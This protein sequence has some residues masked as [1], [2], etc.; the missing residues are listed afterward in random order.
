VVAADDTSLKIALMG[1]SEQ[2]SA[3]LEYFKTQQWSYNRLVV[4][5]ANFRTPERDA[6]D[7]QQVLQHQPDCHSTSPLILRSLRWKDIFQLFEQLHSRP[8][9][10]ENDRN[11]MEKESLWLPLHTPVKSTE[12]CQ[13]DSTA[14]SQFQFLS[15]ATDGPHLFHSSTVEQNEE[16]TNLRLELVAAQEDKRKSELQHRQ[17]Q[18]E[19]HQLRT[20]LADLEESGDI[21][22]KQSAENLTRLTEERF[23]LECSL[24][25]L[26]EQ[27]SGHKEIEQMQIASLQQSLAEVQKAQ[28]QTQAAHQHRERELQ[29]LLDKANENAEL[30]TVA[31]NNQIKQ[32]RQNQASL[33]QALRE[34]R[35]L[36]AQVQAKHHQRESGLQAALDETKKTQS[37]Q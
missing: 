24:Q 13:P 21:F 23:N 31:L 11:I 10:Y 7:G 8:I 33:K 35:V 9:S 15:R 34:S 27:Q 25:Q 36:S 3:R 22:H 29:A 30:V 4:A 12:N 14:G 20:W 32:L 16:I 26:Q 37:R 6:L 2:D 1:I 19:L 17:T 5:K 28:E 18:S